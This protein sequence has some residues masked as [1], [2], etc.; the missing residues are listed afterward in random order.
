MIKKDSSMN[1]A[2]AGASRLADYY[3]PYIEHLH[4]LLSQVDP[5]AIEQIGR[6]FLD[7]RAANQ[8]I[9]FAGNGGSAATASH[10]AQDLA[11]VGRKVGIPG[12]RSLS[13]A[14]S[15]PHITAVA[16]DYSYADI[17]SAQMRDVFDRGDVLVVISASG[18][19]LNVIKAVQVAKDKGGIAVG[20]LGFDGGELSR[21]C[22][23]VVVV[24]SDK[25]EYG[26]VEDAHMIFDHI[27][28]SY[29]T[30]YLWRS[31]GT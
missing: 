27:I 17:F 20:L 18:N 22:D 9:F 12:F 3:L 21:M 1:A 10:F 31:N 6:V 25:G 26:P 8:T 29:L 14:D 13:L 5:Q 4:R 23:H 19:S 16:N 11:E 7:A 24:R 28:T 2:L 30:A 15:T